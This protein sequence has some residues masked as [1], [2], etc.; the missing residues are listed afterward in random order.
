MHHIYH[1]LFWV[2][3]LGFFLPLG[4]QRNKILST[5]AVKEAAFNPKSYT[6]NHLLVGQ[7]NCFTESFAIAC[8]L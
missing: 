8:H 6:F 3:E 5:V 4:V 2:F 1:H 7:Q